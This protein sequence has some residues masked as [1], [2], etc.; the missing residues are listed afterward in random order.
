MSPSLRLEVL[1]PA[2][3]TDL[4]SPTHSI[5]WTRAAMDVSTLT[6]VILDARLDP[7]MADT[8]RSGRQIR[9]MTA[10]LDGWRY[11]YSGKVS[12]AKVSYPRLDRQVPDAKRARIEISAVDAMQAFGTTVEPR[13]VATAGEL[14][15]LLAGSG[16]PWR[17]NGTSTPGPASP[18]VVAYNEGSFLADQIAI[19]RDTLSGYAWVANDGALDFFT[20][21]AMPTVPVAAFSDAARSGLSYSAVDVSYDSADVLDEVSVEFLRYKPVAEATESVTYGPY[22]RPG[23]DGTNAKTFTIVGTTED[24]AAIE[25]FALSVLA[26]NNAA[27]IRPVSM[28]TPVRNVDERTAAA[29]MEPCALVRVAYEQRLDAMVRVETAEHTVT[30]NADARSRFGDGLA[31]TTSYTFGPPE[32]V[33]RP[34]R[35]ALVKNAPVQ[36]RLEATEY[37]AATASVTAIAASGAAAEAQVDASDAQDRTMGYKPSSPQ[38]EITGPRVRMAQR[39]GR[40]YLDFIG[41]TVSA[42]ISAV[43]D[44]SDQVLRLDSGSDDTNP[45]T[46]LVLRATNGIREAIVRGDK[47]RSF[48]QIVAEAGA[49]VRNGLKVESGAVEFL[50]NAGVRLD[51]WFQH[52]RGTTRWYGARDG[53]VVRTMNADGRTTIAHDFPVTPTKVH[54]G[55]VGSGD[56]VFYYPHVVGKNA[57][58]FTVEVRRRSTEAI[59]NGMEFRIDYSLSS[60]DV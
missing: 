4:L 17:V 39:G 26:R 46:S 20:P 24:P 53:S 21:D 6:A 3:W 41:E 50:G 38:T 8:L 33:A 27:Q 14:R 54:V 9:L 43:I 12:Q 51:T 10:T 13:S 18:L 16:L 19:T 1:L 59:A 28:S 40:G 55:L 37:T 29:A 49:V 58:D 2:G 35:L 7:S 44:G 36:N 15:T 30:A 23:S 48:G 47:L 31:W 11:L 22:R 32:A 25:A 45:G 42:Y 34:Q 56:A 60:T 52:Q 57:S 5:S